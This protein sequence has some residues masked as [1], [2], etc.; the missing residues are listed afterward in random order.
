MIGDVS[1]LVHP[2]FALFNLM[3]YK[4]LSPDEKL[5][6]FVKCFWQYNP[7]SVGQVHTILPNGCFE[8]FFILVGDRLESVVLS[9]LRTRPYQVEIPVGVEVFAVR[10]LLPASEFLLQRSIAGVLDGSEQL[11]TFPTE[12][13]HLAVMTF[14]QRTAFMSDMLHQMLGAFHPEDAKMKLMQAAYLQ[15]KLWLM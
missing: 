15:G 7:G 6:P 13:H 5:L 12:Y 10:F 1:L 8:L 2:F 9:G 4:E 11:Q 3:E 14:P